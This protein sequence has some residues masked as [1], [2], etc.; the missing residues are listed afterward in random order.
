M[1]LLLMTCLVLCLGSLYTA[2]GNIPEKSSGP[3]EV[4]LNINT[5]LTFDSSNALYHVMFQV[6]FVLVSLLFIL[7]FIFCVILM[8]ATGIP[9]RTYK[10]SCTKEE[11]ILQIIHMGFM[12]YIIL[13][14]SSFDTSERDIDYLFPKYISQRKWD[15]V[16]IW[17]DCCTVNNYS[18]W[19]SCHEAIP[20]S[21]CQSYGPRCEH[22]TSLDQINNVTNYVGRRKWDKVQIWFDCC[23]VN[24]FTYWQSRHEVVPGSYCKDYCT[25]CEHFISLDQINK[26]GCVANVANYI[27]QRKWDRVQTCFDCCIV[28]DYTYWLRGCVPNVT[29]HVN[30]H[31]KCCLRNRDELIVDGNVDTDEEQWLIDNVAPR[32][33]NDYNIN[34]ENNG[35]INCGDVNGQ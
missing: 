35:D 32:E 17:F 28:N 4:T 24:N 9:P 34:I 20:G 7:I 2:V 8:L 15:K 5:K 13:H 16:Q 33:E 3:H 12:V 11:L 30:T 25:Q 31:L 14:A 26:R 10:D 6:F 29:A 21:N 27:G 1:V 19:Y 23:G 18:Y 22:L